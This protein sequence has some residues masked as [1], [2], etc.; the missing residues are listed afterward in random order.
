MSGTGPA[1]TMGSL[2]A[3]GYPFLNCTRRE[4]SASFTSIVVMKGDVLWG[5]IPHGHGPKKKKKMERRHPEGEPT[6][7]KLVVAL[8]KAPPLVSSLSSQ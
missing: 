4:M 3:V 6:C 1:G 5:L 8:P 2:S 7:S